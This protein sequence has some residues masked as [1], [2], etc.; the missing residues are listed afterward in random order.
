MDGG[1]SGL[2]QRSWAGKGTLGRT[3][4]VPWCVGLHGVLGCQGNAAHGNDHEDA[5]LKVAQVQDVM[6]QAAKAVGN[7]QVCRGP[8]RPWA[9]KPFSSTI[10]L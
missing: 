8:L 10:S 9:H 4:V 1:E 2:R 7:R 6:A 5:H 3:H